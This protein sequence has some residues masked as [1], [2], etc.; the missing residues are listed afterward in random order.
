MANIYRKSALDKLSS[1]EQLDRSITIISPSFW[2]AVLGIAAIIVVALLWSIFGRLP[3]SVST[4]GIYMGEDGIRSVAAQT[5]GIVDEV[6]VEN[7]DQVKKGQKLVHIDTSDAEDELAKLKEQRESVVAVT[8]DS[9]DDVGTSANQSLLDIKAQK[10]MT[11]ASLTTNQ[12]I[13]EARQKELADQESLTNQAKSD[14]EDARESYLASLEGSDVSEQ[15]LAYQQA[16]TNLSSSQSYYESIKSS[17]SQA[18]A[19]SA[20]LAEQKAGLETA[21]GQA[22]A[23]Y[24]KAQADGDPVA[25]GIAQ[26]QLSTYQSQLASVESQLAVAATQLEDSA[27]TVDEWYDRVSEAQ[28]EYNAAEDDYIAAMNA[29][30]A[31]QGNSNKEGVAYNVALQNYT[32]ELSTRR[33]LEDS[34][35]Q[36]MAQVAADQ[37]NLDKQNTAIKYQ[38][39]TARSAALDSLDQ[40]IEKMQKGIDHATIEANRDGYI[41][42][43]HVAVGNPITE[44]ST[45]CR[46]S[47]DTDEEQ[48]IICY[49]PVAQGRKIKPGMEVMIYPS[50]VNRQEY[51]HIN[52][53]VLEVSDYVISA[54][55]MTNQIGDYSLVQMFQA[56]GPVIRL[57]CELKKDDSTLSGYEWSSK[58]GAEIELTEGTIVSADVVIEEKAPIT[59]IIPYLKEKFSVNREDTL[60][61][62]QPEQ[63]GGN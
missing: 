4:N 16:Q 37:A 54:E 18:E 33:G 1:P 2:I 21:I 10:I 27:Q 35:I 42:G 13:L 32:T 26:S 39:D 7:G 50:T 40:Q 34:V 63:Q 28:S 11:D 58:K 20:S 29:A 3:V 12:E 38:F 55:E 17:L 25:E 23:A 24:E 46:I 5:T 62:M 61:Q 44:G 51:G 8:F 48:V 57:Q 49:A 22:Q 41:A 31:Q 53:T 19:A 36:L 52:G 6:F 30:A 45:V 56:S 59:M 43:M 15:Q 47:G 9:E 14:Y 60:Q